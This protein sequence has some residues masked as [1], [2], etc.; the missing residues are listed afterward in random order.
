[1]VDMTNTNESGKVPEG[2]DS[3]KSE[4]IL[5]LT[6]VVEAQPDADKEIIELNFK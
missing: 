3:S 2:T 5:E 1:M 6:D 4:D